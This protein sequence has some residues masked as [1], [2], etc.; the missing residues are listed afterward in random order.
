MTTAKSGFFE[1]SSCCLPIIHFRTVLIILAC[2]QIKRHI[3]GLRICSNVDIFLQVIVQ[4]QPSSVPDEWGTT[5]D[6]QTRPRVV[7]RGIDDDH[8][9]IPEG[10]RTRFLSTDLSY[11]FLY[12]SL[13]WS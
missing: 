11:Q 6:G 1:S 13:C 3:K 12:S 4:F 7:K 5:Q 2:F 9:E 8:D 10:E